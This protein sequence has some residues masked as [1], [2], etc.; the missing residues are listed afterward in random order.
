[1]IFTMRFHDIHG[2]YEEGK[3]EQGAEHGEDS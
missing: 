1:M 2:K 3:D